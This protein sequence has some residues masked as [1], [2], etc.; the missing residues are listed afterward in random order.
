MKR[1]PIMFYAAMR[2]ALIAVPTLIVCGQGFAADELCAPNGFPET[3][4]SKPNVAIIMRI[5][6]GLNRRWTYVSLV[7]PEGTLGLE[8]LSED[9]EESFPEEN[10][11]NEVSEF[12]V[13]KVIKGDLDPTILLRRPF[14]IIG[15]VAS[16]NNLGKI[17]LTAF[18][19]AKPDG[20]YELPYHRIFS[21]TIN[22]SAR[23]DSQTYNLHLDCDWVLPARYQQ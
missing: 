17:F 5:D 10:N 2:S 1:V 22:S 18:D 4:L 21:L 7:T 6:G 11:F 12:L 3:Y 8:E 13:L 19:D 23:V 20:T 16:I 15:S 9:M 14:G